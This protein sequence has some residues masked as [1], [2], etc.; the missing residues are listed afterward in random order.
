MEG[1]VCLKMGHQIRLLRRRK[2]LTQD[3]LAARANI[4]LKYLQNL[5]GRKPKIASIVTAEKIA[6]GLGLPLWKFLKF[7][8]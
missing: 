4:S 2:G 5:E 3:E 7:R 8:S 1:N 6:K